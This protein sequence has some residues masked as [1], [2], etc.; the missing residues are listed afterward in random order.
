MKRSILVS[1]LALS[2]LVIG[3]AHH[4]DVRPGAD[5]KNRVVTTATE[6]EKASRGSIAQATHYCEQFKQAPRIVSEGTVYTGEMDENT[7]KV[8]RK[9]SNA[10]ILVGG[11]NSD[12]DHPV[13]PVLGAGQVGA[14]MTSGEDYRTEMVFECK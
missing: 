1:L 3:C 4:R 6:A 5:G 12:Y 2:G 9:A 8:L 7:R 11:V 10:A 14:I 13:N